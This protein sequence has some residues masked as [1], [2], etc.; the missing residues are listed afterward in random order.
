[1]YSSFNSIVFVQCLSSCLNI[2]FLFILY[3][4]NYYLGESRSFENILFFHRY[5]QAQFIYWKTS[6]VSIKNNR[7]YYPHFPVINPGLH[8]V[9]SNSITMEKTYKHTYLFTKT[10][11][12]KSTIKMITKSVK[13]FFNIMPKASKMFLP[14]TDSDIHGKLGYLTQLVIFGK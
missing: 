12:S 14:S 8:T 9:N 6:N 13:K 11:Q 7:K 3:L 1:M 2:I 10:V 4:N 5:Y